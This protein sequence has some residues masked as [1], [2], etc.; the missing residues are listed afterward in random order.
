MPGK[1]RALPYRGGNADVGL[2]KRHEVMQITDA[3]TQNVVDVIW[4][5]QIETEVLPRGVVIELTEMQQSR[6]GKNIF[7]EQCLSPARM[8]VYNVWIKPGFLDLQ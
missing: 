2:L 1:P 3:Q 7:Q 5:F 4:K 6:F 8:S